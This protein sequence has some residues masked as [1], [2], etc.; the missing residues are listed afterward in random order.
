MKKIVHPLPPDWSAFALLLIDIQQDFWPQKTACHFP[1]FEER[2]AQLLTFCRA[3]GIDV[4]HLHAAF[5]PDQSDWMAK[6][7]L[8]GHVP[9]VRETAGAEVLPCAAALPGELV[10][11]KQSFDGFQTPALLPRLRARGK[12]FLLTAGIQTSV[13]VLFTTAAAAQLGFLTAVVADCCADRPERH[14]QALKNYPFIFECTSVD[15]LAARHIDWL[16]MLATLD[17]DNQP[18]P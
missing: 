10:I 11:E 13:C 3:V 18:Q 9:C 4:I 16:A 8:L 17:Q 1:V 15:Q 14:A 12:R 5:A 2:V 6:Y 7:K